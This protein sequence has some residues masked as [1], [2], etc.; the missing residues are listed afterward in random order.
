MVAEQEKMGRR[1]QKKLK[2]RNEILDAAVS[3]FTQKGFLET[4]IADIMKEADMGLGTFYNYFSSK[5][6]VLL[7]L[8][9][10]SAESFG[11]RMTAIMQETSSNREILH[12][13]VMFTARLVAEN[14]YLLPLLF[15]EAM[16]HSRSKGSR[17]EGMDPPKFMGAFLNIIRNGQEKGEFRQDVSAEIISELFHSMF[18]GAAYSRVDISFEENIEMKLKLLIAGISKD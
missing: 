12:E 3:Q 1:E 15:T 5:E 14:R 16:G 2:A 8:L 7:K 9:N 10:R 6:D 13:M 4:S 11:Q 17:P 18:Q